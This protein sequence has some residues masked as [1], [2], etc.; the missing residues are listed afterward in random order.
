[1]WDD[2]STATMVT[3]LAQGYVKNPNQC[4]PACV[5]IPGEEYGFYINTANGFTYTPANLRLDILNGRT[6]A[7]VYTGVTTMSGHLVTGS[8]TNRNYYTTFTFPTIAK[9]MY[10]FRLYDTSAATVR[11]TSNLFEVLSP[12]G[13]SIIIG[14][15]DFSGSDFYF[16]DFYT[17]S[18]TF[19]T[20]DDYL[21]NTMYVQYKTDRRFYDFY[22]HLV[23][24]F[25]QKL[26]IRMNQIDS[27][28]EDEKEIYVEQY[29]GKPRNFV[30]EQKWVYT[31]ETYY[32]DEGMHKAAY[33]MSL[34][35][36]LIIN[37]KVYYTKS[38]YKI[39]TIFDSK[40]SKGTFEVYEEEFASINRC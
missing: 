12:I 26:R 13:G 6:G 16:T 33:V 32:Y 34:H 29:S 30:S 20:E 18:T 27:Q 31:L 40:S 17:Q 2:G 22:W 19:Q 38:T 3:A 23:P 9:G 7:L 5:F 21:R 28:P 4:Q 35:D 10:R 24:S 11:F 15:G 37:S 25:Y 8:A 14:P 36:N 39:D 1:M